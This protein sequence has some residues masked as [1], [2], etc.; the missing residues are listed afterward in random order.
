MPGGR[1][2]DHLGGSRAGPAENLPIRG[3]FATGVLQATPGSGPDTR[4][5]LPAAHGSQ[6]VPVWAG[7][8]CRPAAGG[9]GPS[10]APDGPPPPRQHRFARVRV[11]RA[12]R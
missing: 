10:G 7:A 8:G 2:T 9:G 3:S 6:R 1:D 5:A 11:R 4:G 12:K